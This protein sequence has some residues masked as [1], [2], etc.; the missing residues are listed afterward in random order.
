MA[1][2]MVEGNMLGG[3]E[4]RIVNERRDFIQYGLLTMGLHY[5]SLISVKHIYSY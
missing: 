2:E 5:G 1:N 3:V 4:K